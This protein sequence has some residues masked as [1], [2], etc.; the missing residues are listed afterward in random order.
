M[1]RRKRLLKLLFGLVVGVLISQFTYRDPV[2]DLSEDDPQVPGHG[3]VLVGV[4]TAAKYLDSRARA[5]YDTWGRKVPGRIIFFSSEGSTSAHVPL[6]ALPHVDDAYPPQKKSFHMLKYL[7]DHFVDEFEW[8]VRADDDVFV[9][10][11]QLEALLRSVDSRKAWFIGQTGRGNTEELGMLSLESDENFCMGG[12]GVIFSRETL[13]RV[14]PH[15]EECL[16]RLYTTHEDVELGRCVRRFAGISCT[17]SYEMQV[18]LYHNQSGEAAFSGDLKQKEV[19]RAITLH[20]VKQPQHMYRL[21]KYVKGLKIQA[22]QQECIDLHRGIA[23]S[24]SQMG[25]TIGRLPNASLVQG[26]PLFAAPRGSQLY[27]GDPTLLGMPQSLTRHQPRA[28]QE[29]LDW[30]LISK[31]LYSYKDLNPRRRIGSALKEGL[32]D[33]VRDIMEVINS[34]SKQRGR[35]IDFKE[36]L[37]GYWRLDPV[38]GIDLILDLLLVYRK[39]RGHKMTVQVRRH[40]YV[41]QTFTGIFVREITK[42]SPSSVAVPKIVKHIISTFEKIPPI[43]P[44]ITAKNQRQT[45]NFIVPLS[46]RFDTFRRFLRLYEDICIKGGEET[47]LFVILYQSVGFEAS[48]RAIEGLQGRYLNS[49]VSVVYVN[50]SFSRAKALENGLKFVSDDDLVLFIDVDMVFDARSL[51]RVRQNTVKGRSVYFPIV[52]SLFDPRITNRSLGIDEESGFWRQFGFGI[53]SIFKNDYKKL[54]GF[55]LNIS[56]WGFED[57]AFYDTA[58]QSDLRIVRSADPGLVHV[59]HPIHCDIN[60]DSNQRN[61]C[62]GTQANMLGSRKQLEAIFR[63][64]RHLFS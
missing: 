11:E 26:L 56:G 14:A 34:Y 1:S 21:D 30:E 5:V 35:V 29:V 55:N 63:R 10:T 42:A 57:V 59:Y 44:S 25:Y 17:W 27:L 61:M 6:V 50:E 62:L 23:S 19:H 40:A 41:Q 24:M 28:V 64:F 22:Y 16:G 46:G 45:V 3:L 48:A 37:Y 39:Y 47:R 20:P 58:I 43:F 15:V 7:H 33:V 8:F 31:T 18:I 38:H 60:L 49:G 2:C 52:Y 36:I 12:P 9:K 51:Q 13:K 53:V 4:M 54:G 32:N